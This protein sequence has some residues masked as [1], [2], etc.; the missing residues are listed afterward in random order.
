M[1][2]VGDKAPAFEFINQH[3]KR[4]HFPSNFRGKKVALSFLRH[5]GCPLCKEKVSELAEL[6]S[7][8]GDSNIELIVVVDGTQ[9]RIENFVKRNNIPFHLVGDKEK[10]I[11]KLYGLSSGTFAQVVS[12]S[13]LKSSIRATFKGHIHGRFEGDEFQLP[14]DFIVDGDGKIV[15]AHYGTNIADSIK[16]EV[17]MKKLKEL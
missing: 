15:F 5:L 11:Y 9:T 2:T 8:M 12:P 4:F 10:K 17:L 14:G 16:A 6:Y 1:V 3:N 7:T 13:V